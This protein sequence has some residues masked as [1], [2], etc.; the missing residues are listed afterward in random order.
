MLVVE[1]ADVERRLDVIAAALGAGV[2]TVQLRD[3]RAAGG[4]LLRAAT[5]LRDL[6]RG[7]GAALIV[8]DRADVASA[9]DA[10]GVHLP[11][12]SLP[13]SAAR[14]VIGSHAWI[15]RSTHAPAEAVAAATGGADYVVLGPVFATPSKERYGAPLGVAALAITRIEV[16]LIA[17]G[18]V[19]AANVLEIV[20]AGA[21]GVAVVRAILDAADPAGAARALV[22]ALDAA[23]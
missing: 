1:V 20:R 15:G 14:A 6:S 5:T 10:D 8:N 4:A 17:I 22:A 21:A 19:S 9:A 12:Q 11:A 23:R 2:D 3:R 18:G 13:I 7:A 16:P